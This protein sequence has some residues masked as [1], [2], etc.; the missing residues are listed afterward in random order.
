LGFGFER[1]GLAERPRP[2]EQPIARPMVSTAHLVRAGA[3]LRARVR[4]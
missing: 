2:M 4:A 1:A 3:R